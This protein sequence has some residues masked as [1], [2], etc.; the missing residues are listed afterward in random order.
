MNNDLD[1]AQALNYLKLSLDLC[2]CRR[3]NA[4]QKGSIEIYDELGLAH[5]MAFI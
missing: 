1:E 3:Y 5:V 2:I 4:L